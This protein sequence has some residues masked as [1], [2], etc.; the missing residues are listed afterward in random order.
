MYPPRCLPGPASGVLAVTSSGGSLSQA[1]QGGCR[2]CVCTVRCAGPG[3]V[4]RPRPRA[5]LSLA[6]L[7][8]CF[9]FSQLSCL[10]RLH[11]PETPEASPSPRLP[12]RK[13]R[14]MLPGLAPAGRP[15]GSQWPCGLLGPTQWGPGGSRAG[16]QVSRPLRWEGAD[17]FWSTVS[18]SAG[19]EGGWWQRAVLCPGGGHREA[20]LAGLSL[21]SRLL[22]FLVESAEA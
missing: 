1:R 4:E 10:A 6:G 8:L 22:L 16:I 14:V 11:P 2:S 3:L 12:A 19:S 13:L 5:A 17:C 18:P 20:L 9:D 7:C 15:A 21:L